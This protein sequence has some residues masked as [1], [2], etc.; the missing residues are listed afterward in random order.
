MEVIQNPQIFEV[1]QSQNV[2]KRIKSEKILKENIP[3]K[4]VQFEMI[5]VIHQFLFYRSK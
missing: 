1:I 4:T 5:V 2:R 3:T